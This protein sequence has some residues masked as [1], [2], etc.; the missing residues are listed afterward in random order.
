MSVL[1]I[2]DATSGAALG[3]RRPPEPRWSHALT[4]IASH[5]ARRGVIGI[6]IVIRERREVGRSGSIVVQLSES[7][8][9]TYVDDP[10]AF[11]VIRSLEV[12]L[13][14]GFT[15]LQVRSNFLPRSNRR[16][17]KRE[18]SAPPDPMQTRLRELATMFA[19]V[20]FGAVSRQGE[21]LPR[22]LARTAR[23]SA[24]AE[25]RRRRRCE[26]SSG[27]PGFVPESQDFFEGHCFDHFAISDTLDDDDVPF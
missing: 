10:G 11:A 18:H 2:D 13:Q 5:Q 21:T 25:S 19:S 16:Q 3:E 22:R 23:I 17:G 24:L 27:D 15:R 9:H 1:F 12:A 20:T 6:G 26:S 7:H 4:V 14:H 8:C